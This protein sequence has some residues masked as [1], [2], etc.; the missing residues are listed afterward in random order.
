MT[1]EVMTDKE[2]QE[3][4]YKLWEPGIYDCTFLSEVTFG[5][6]TIKSEEKLSSNGNPI[7][8]M[9]AKIFAKD[10]SD[11]I[12]TIIDYVPLTGKMRFKHKHLA[13]TVGLKDR[14]E[15]KLLSLSDILHKSGKCELSI[16]PESKD[17]KTGKI[18]KTR[19]VID[20]YI[21]KDNP[22][23]GDFL[24]DELPDFMA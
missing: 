18:Y 20:D 3:S 6:T 5:T 15:Q 13:E 12:T 2:E 24:N 10:G 9:I 22:A 19:N 7:W 1:Y 23:S 11:F 8:V 16:K 17:T 4:K 14:Y 21:P